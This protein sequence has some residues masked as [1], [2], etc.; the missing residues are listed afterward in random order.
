MTPLE[1]RC[2]LFSK[3]GAEHHA[4]FGEQGAHPFGAGEIAA[5]GG[6]DAALDALQETGLFGQIAPAC[7]V[8][9]LIDKSVEGRTGS[10]CLFLGPWAVRDAD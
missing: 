6:A 1:N 5:I 10:E 7:S 3:A 8:W 2:G 9:Q 4:P